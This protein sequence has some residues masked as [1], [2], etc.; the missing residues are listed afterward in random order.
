MVLRFLSLPYRLPTT[1]VVAVRETVLR[2][3]LTITQVLQAVPVAVAAALTSPLVRAQ[4]QANPVR[5][6]RVVVAALDL[7]V[8]GLVEPTV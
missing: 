1:Q 6:T 3:Q 7:P 2:A 4:A 5:Q 8:T